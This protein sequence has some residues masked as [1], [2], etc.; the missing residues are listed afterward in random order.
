MIMLI[1][2]YFTGRQIR[3]PCLS[4]SDA[5]TPNQKKKLRRAVFTASPMAAQGLACPSMAIS[6]NSESDSDDSFVWPRAPTSTKKKICT[7]YSDSESGDDSQ[8]SL[9]LPI[10]AKPKPSTSQPACERLPGPVS[11]I[12][13]KLSLL[14]DPQ[15][16]EDFENERFD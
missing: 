11:K 16:F 13:T 12:F 2:L 4:V 14:G 10:V 3:L 7:I 6:S 15:C 8:S 5:R 9:L 1:M